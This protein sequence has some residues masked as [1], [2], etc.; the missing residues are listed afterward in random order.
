MIQDRAILPMA[1]QQ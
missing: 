1:D